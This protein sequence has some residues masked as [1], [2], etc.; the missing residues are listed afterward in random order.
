MATKRTS[1]APPKAGGSRIKRPKLDRKVDLKMDVNR[2]VDMPPGWAF[3][4]NCPNHGEQHFDFNPFRAD[5]RE[6]LAGHLRDAIWNLRHE[7]EGK[8]LGNYFRGVG[9]F[10][11]FLDDVEPSGLVVSSLDQIDTAV[12]RRYT[13]W[14]GGQISMTGPNRGKALSSG[15][16]KIRY[17]W[18]KSLLKNRQKRHLKAVHPDLDFPRNPFPNS[19]SKVVHRS[20]YSIGEQS[21]ITTALNADLKRIHEDGEPLDWN[22]VLAVHQIIFGLA[23]GT[24]K[25]SIIELRRN[26]LMDHPLKD[27]RFIQTFKRRG[28]ST[29]ATSIREQESDLVVDKVK[30]IPA[31]IAE[32][33]EFLC[34][35]TALLMDEA[36]KEKR[37]LVFLVRMK[38]HGRKGLVVGLDDHIVNNA[39][40]AFVKRHDLKDDHGRSLQLN[41]ARLRPTMGTNLY[42]I[43]KD[44][45]KVQQA[46][47]H[48]HVSTTEMYV[49]QRLESERDH[50]LV[51]ESMEQR[52]TPMVI[53]GK[54]MIAA[55][56]QFPANV[57]A[58][59]DGGYNTGIARCKNPF[60]GKNASRRGEAAVQEEIESVCKKFIACFRCPNMTVFEDDLWRLFSFYY[61]LLSE[62]N[63]IHPDHW[64]KTYAP[65][66]R[67]VDRHISPLFPAD[68]V[69]EARVKA[70]ANPHPAWRG[71]VL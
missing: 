44:I 47:G 21:R 38:Q 33:F 15:S 23:L 56:G 40:I 65:I 2:V 10:W 49:E 67:R 60:R 5:G 27:R 69:A 8:T 70:Q 32:H 39:I 1:K 59:L 18:L 25:Q 54:V 64:M 61:R 48:A 43:T 37:G 52:F 31:N 13:G 24:N 36:P 28:H 26:A 4:I 45:R 66:I 58:L 14:L 3:T 50:K 6:D 30:T 41:I 35:Y 46:L 12:L 55:D 29:H 57:Q 20:P 63:K 62:R 7:A 19:N 51:L 22:Q 53:E 9:Y 71:P 68:K 16:Q 34:V 17:D 11:K 42:R